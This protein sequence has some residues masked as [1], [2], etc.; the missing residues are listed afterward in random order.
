M[1]SDVSNASMVVAHF[2]METT[3]HGTE[4]EAE[5]SALSGAF[6]GCKKDHLS[7]TSQKAF[8]QTAVSLQ[9]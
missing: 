6:R 7:H 2:H 4:F 9:Y 3:Q 5:D 8:E 1:N